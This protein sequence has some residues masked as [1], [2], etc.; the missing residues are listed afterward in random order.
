MRPANAR[1]RVTFNGRVIGDTRNA[2][3][4]EENGYSAVYYL[5]RAD[6]TMDALVR[7]SHRTHCPFKGDASYF[8]LK[9]GPENAVWSYENP[10]DET[11]AI[12]DLLAF[13][14]DKVSIDVSSE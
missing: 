6:V 8:S 1:V 5:P 4:L 14:R 3:V 2:V 9:D 13:Y 7:S 10:Y 11:I 12:K